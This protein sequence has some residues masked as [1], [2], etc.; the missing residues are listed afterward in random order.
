MNKVVR[1]LGAFEMTI[2]DLMGALHKMIGNRAGIRALELD[3]GR[4]DGFCC[5]W[6]GRG[7]KT[8]NKKLF[9]STV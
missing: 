7:Q 6:F 3:D 5:A 9:N 1:I 8:L 4:E 2:L